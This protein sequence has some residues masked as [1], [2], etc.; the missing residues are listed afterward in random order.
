[1]NDEPLPPPG[2]EAIARLAKLLGVGIVIDDVI[3]GPPVRI[4]ATG[5]LDGERTRL[6]GVGEPGPH[7][8][9]VE[10]EVEDRGE[11]EPESRQREAEQLVLVL[12]AS[13]LR[14][15]PHARGDAWPKRPLLLAGSH[16]RAIRRRAARS[17]GSAAGTVRRAE[18]PEIRRAL[19]QN[20]HPLARARASATTRSASA[21]FP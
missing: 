19:V 12:R 16:A 2:P 8:A 11:D 13:A 15:L 5:L 20:G 17:S 21:R 14:P 9:A 18:H 1:M 4:E 3:E 6:E 10:P 7:R